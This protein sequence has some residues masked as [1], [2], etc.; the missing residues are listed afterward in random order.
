MISL[1]ICSTQERAAVYSMRRQAKARVS[2]AASKQAGKEEGRR[3]RERETEK[4]GGCDDHALNGSQ[5]GERERESTRAS[6]SVVFRLSRI[7]F[8][9]L[10]HPDCIRE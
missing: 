2:L 5:E 4:E 6:V 7:D 3:K 8:S 9:L 1:A 10:F